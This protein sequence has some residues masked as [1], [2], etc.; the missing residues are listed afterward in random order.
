MQIEDKKVVGLG[1]RLQCIHTNCKPSILPDVC[2]LGGG[3]VSSALV[4]KT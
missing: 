2:V 3:M 1:T 4:C